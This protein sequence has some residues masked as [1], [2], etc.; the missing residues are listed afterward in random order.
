MDDIPAD[1]RQK[2]DDGDQRVKQ[3]FDSLL[4]IRSA[5]LLEVSEKQNEN[6]RLNNKVASLEAENEQ[7]NNKVAR[8]EAEI[9]RG[10]G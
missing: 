3:A 8:L 10:K 7:L 4:H 1:I 5:V 2:I 9:A 6:E